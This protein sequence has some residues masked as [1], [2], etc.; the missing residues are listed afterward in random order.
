MKIE[1]D[2]KILENIKED[3]IKYLIRVGF[4]KNSR[5]ERFI[6]NNLNSVKNLYV[7]NLEEKFGTQMVSRKD[8]IAIDQKFVIFNSDKTKVLG[9]KKEYYELIISQLGHELWHNASNSNDV[10]GIIVNNDNKRFLALNEGITQLL[11]EDISG[12]TLSKYSDKTY[13]YFKYIAQILR[14]STSNEILLKS[15]LYHTDDLK[16]S[17]NTLAG[18]SDFYDQFNEYLSNLLYLKKIVIRSYKAKKIEKPSDDYDKAFN[19]IYRNRIV[20]QYK[21]L[22]LNI[23]IPKLKTLTKEKQKI[24]IESILNIFKEDY[25]IYRIVSEYLMEVIS[26]K[27]AEINKR[28]Q[29]L[30]KMNKVK[31]EQ[32]VML[33]RFAIDAKTLYEK[34]F[35]KV[36]QDG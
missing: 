1:I 8:S 7:E 36:K 33:E 30:N 27:D 5:E 28:K 6:R 26:L 11:A 34:G 16:N 15:Y 23:V 3:I 2:K 10:H 35:I 19:L 22:I 13:R 25:E 21:S 18:D 14:L 9:L 24:Y 20:V 32:R 12:F 31:E 17:C 29:Q 4:I